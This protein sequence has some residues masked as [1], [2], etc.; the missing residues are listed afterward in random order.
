MFSRHKNQTGSGPYLTDEQT[1][2]PT[3]RPQA[4]EMDRQAPPKRLASG[5][6]LPR[7]ARS[8]RLAGLVLHARRIHA[9]VA[10][11]VDPIPQSTIAGRRLDL[12]VIK[13]ATKLDIDVDGDMYYRDSSGQRK[14]SD[15]WCDHQITSFGWQSKRYWVYQLR[16]N[17]NGCVDDIISAD[18]G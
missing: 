3:P 13:G 18:D 14:S 7:P 10:R 2:R 16:E 12:A 11:G 4:P 8:A 5:R 9:I 15:L 17:L 6:V 1:H